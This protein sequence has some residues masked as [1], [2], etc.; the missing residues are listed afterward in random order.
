VAPS[1]F[2]A[3]L[4]LSLLL[5][6]CG[7]AQES[8]RHEGGT[9][10]GLASGGLQ[11]RRYGIE[12]TLPAGWDGTLTRGALRAASF[13]LG[14]S[15]PGD[16]ISG[17]GVLV[18][19]F[20]TDP[21]ADSPPPDRSLYPEVDAVPTLAADDFNPPEPGTLLAGGVARRTFALSGR[22][23]VLFVISQSPEPRAEALAGVNELLASIEVKPGD[24]YPGAVEPPRF[25]PRSGW[26]VGDSGSRPLM[27]DGN[28]LSAWA[29]TIPYRDQW[30]AA[31]ADETLQA[32]PY[33][34]IVVWVGLT[35][36]NRFA[37][38]GP[39]AAP[40]LQLA[41]FDRRAAW[42]G[43]VRDLPE[44]LLWARVGDQYQLEVRVFFGQSDPAPE[45]LREADAVLAGLR[46]PEWGPWER[47]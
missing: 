6:G 24:F 10:A 30:N 32:L 17:G 47:P 36:T 38:R 23:F 3:A 41:D 14:R 33:D 31:H 43:Q 27:A 20:E 21:A 15:R 25:G 46:L 8:A 40:P 42:E 44:Y 22:L 28:F 4:A 18:E 9:T 12:A 37:P 7:A 26:Y 1:G 34:G 16:A 13:D 2:L 5:A 11:L 39:E 29:S 45:L 19:C 35:T